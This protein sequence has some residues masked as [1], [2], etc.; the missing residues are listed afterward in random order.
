[1]AHTHPK[2]Q[3]LQARSIRRKQIQH[4]LPL[5]SIVTVL[6]LSGC[7][8]TPDESD[9]QPIA[10]PVVQKVPALFYESTAQ[11]E[12]D[13]QKQEM[14]YQAKLK[15]YEL[16]ASDTKKSTVAPTAPALSPSDC[17]AQMA[18]AKREHDRHAPVYQTQAECEAD[19]VR[20]ETTP[21]YISSGGYRP[22]FGGT[23]LY[24]YWTGASS[25]YA[26]EG[27]RVYPPHTVYAGSTPREVITPE[28]SVLQNNRSGAV[29]APQ[30]TGI[31]ASTRPAGYSA[32]GTITGRAPTRP[33]GYSAQGTITGRSRSGF[34]STF[35]STGSGGK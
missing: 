29:S 34:G 6:A 8:S 1:M 15:A 9:K 11:C 19:R 25:N 32:Q 22:R 35:K 14:D 27:N 10:A 7:A 30:P 31:D 3:N 16:K 2:P 17:E 20:C 18:A 28:G 4:Q 13:T 21:A 12:A 23:Y 26:G 24:P 33:A 5:S